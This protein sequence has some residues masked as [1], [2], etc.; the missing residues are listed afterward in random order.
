MTV[1]MRRF[2]LA[3]RSLYEGKSVVDE[4]R[5]DAM[6][7]LKSILPLSTQFLASISEF[8]EYYEA[9]DYEEWCDMLSDILEETKGYQQL[10]VTL[11][12]IHEDFLTPIKRRK[13]NEALDNFIKGINLAA[14]LFSTMEKALKRLENTAEKAKDNPKKLY[15]KVMEKLAKEI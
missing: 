3:L 6:V 1:V 15:Y 13:Q 7:Y 14:V 4:T 10:C 12:K 11:L 8:F 9:L 2:S 5:K